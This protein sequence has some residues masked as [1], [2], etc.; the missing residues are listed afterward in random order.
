MFLKC[1]FLVSMMNYFI[2]TSIVFYFIIRF[3]I[4]AAKSEKYYS[5]LPRYI[6]SFADA[7]TTHKT[8]I[9]SDRQEKMQYHDKNQKQTKTFESVSMV[10]QA[11]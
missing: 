9:L 5:T 4:F 8:R 10:Q 11:Q 6:Y 3:Y 1:N 7:S 2:F